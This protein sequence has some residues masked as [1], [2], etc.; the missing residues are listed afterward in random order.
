M[1]RLINLVTLSIP[2]MTIPAVKAAP[3]AIITIQRRRWAALIWFCGLADVA[4]GRIPEIPND[5]AGCPDFSSIACS[6]FARRC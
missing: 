2:A 3:T 4:N 5:A 1:P 6:K